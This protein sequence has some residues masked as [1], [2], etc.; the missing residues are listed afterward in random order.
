MQPGASTRT[1]IDRE[2]IHAMRSSSFMSARAHG[3]SVARRFVRLFRHQAHSAGIDQEGL[4]H[5]GTVRRRSRPTHRGR[6]SERARPTRDGHS[7]EPPVHVARASRTYRARSA[8]R[9]RRQRSPAHRR[10]HFGPDCRT[11]RPHA[12]GAV[13]SMARPAVLLRNHRPGRVALP[14]LSSASLCA[15]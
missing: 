3:S 10:H 14:P 6:G 12:G 11:A 1:S 8:F 9:R 13:V 15:G 4:L 5:I 2:S 7:R